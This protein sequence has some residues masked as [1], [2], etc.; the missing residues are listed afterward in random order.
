MTKTTLK[1][2]QHV[3]H[4]ADFRRLGLIGQWFGELQLIGA[5]YNPALPPDKKSVPTAICRVVCAQGHITVRVWRYLR[6]RQRPTCLTC[7]PRQESR[8]KDS[9]CATHLTLAQL[10]GK[11]AALSPERRRL[12]A[13]L[14]ADRKRIAGKQDT[15]EQE[16]LRD[17]YTYAIQIADP[18][19]ELADLAQERPRETRNGSSLTSPSLKYVGVE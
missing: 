2:Y 13:A 17:A 7:H 12:M 14:L 15:S 19:A 11:I 3:K 5:A 1:P 8:P 6:Q 4:L 16:Q 10:A 9:R 18:V